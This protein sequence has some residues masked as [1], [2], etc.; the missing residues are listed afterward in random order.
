MPDGHATGHDRKVECDTMSHPIQRRDDCIF[1]DCIY[2]GKN[3]TS[4][5]RLHEKQQCM[6][7]SARDI[8][9]GRRGFIINTGMAIMAAATLGASGTVA[10]GTQS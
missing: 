8:S 1:P 4:T 2:L 10:A 7:N 9:T 5:R 3:D 6:I